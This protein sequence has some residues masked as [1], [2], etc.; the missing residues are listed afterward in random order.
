V[1]P[2]APVRPLKEVWLRPRRVFRD[3]A[4]LPVGV[5]DYVLAAAQGIGNYLM[6]YQTQAPDSHLSVSDI[7][8]NS[9]RYGPITGVAGVFLFSL[10]YGRLGARIG[11]HF[12]RNQ[13]FHVLAYGGLPVV[14]TL[15]LWALTFLLVGDAAFAAPPGSDIDGFVWIIL[16]V[17]FVA[18][19]LLLFWSYVLQIMG[20]SEILGLPVRKA[21]GLWLAGQL[22]GV[23]AAF[24]LAILVAILFPGVVPSPP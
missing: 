23:L 14:A 2:T 12:T 18:S 7:V 22:L 4:R 24:F 16:R 15:V 20:F 8:A 6:L 19:L 1:I 5:T 17:Q 13:I 21:V 11:G 10:I 9:I 3:L